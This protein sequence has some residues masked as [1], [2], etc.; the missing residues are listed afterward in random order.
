MWTSASGEEQVLTKIVSDYNQIE[1]PGKFVVRKQTDGS[2]T[3]IGI[4]VE[5]IN[6]EAIRVHPILDT[7]I[8]VSSATRSAGA[9]INLILEALT[10]QG[11]TKVSFGIGP[12]NL[13]V[14]SQVTV[15]G[16]NVSARGL[17]L[18]TIAGIEPAKLVWELLYDTDGKTYYFSLIP[19][20][21]AHYDAFGGR[22]TEMIP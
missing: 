9:T 15:G 14:R 12:L 3:I 7:P 1:N 20:Q 10:A 13:L 16:T 11:G 17:L 6:G 5:D 4:S 19:K 22:T 18:Q 2:Y 8:S 21:R